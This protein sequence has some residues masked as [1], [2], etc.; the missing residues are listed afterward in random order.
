MRKWTSNCHNVSFKKQISSMFFQ[1]TILLPNV[2]EV[3]AE[4]NAK[5]N[6]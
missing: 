6:N 5:M 1:V 3:F 2:Y 4:N